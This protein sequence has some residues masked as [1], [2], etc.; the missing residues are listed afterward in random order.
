MLYGVGDKVVTKKPHP[1]GG[2]RWEITR[3]GA[4][5]KLRCLKCGRVVMLTYDEL[6]KKVKGKAND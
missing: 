3:T 1:C 2:N 6:L 4:D 5:Y